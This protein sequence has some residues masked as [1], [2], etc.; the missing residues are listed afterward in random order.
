M[1]Q[2]IVAVPPPPSASAP[3]AVD[4]ALQVP[5]MPVLPNFPQY[6]EYP[7]FPPYEKAEK[8]AETTLPPEMAEPPIE[9]ISP[10][11]D[12][13]AESPVEDT[14]DII[15]GENQSESPVGYYGQVPVTM[16]FAGREI[17]GIIG[18]LNYLKNLADELPEK[19]KTS[20]VQSKIPSIMEKIVNNLKKLV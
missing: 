8:T 1:P 19:V 20:F 13:L 6:P 11:M 3:P 4:P 14:A 17:P 18:L 12:E 2:I 7:P 9:E 16:G 5:R 10:S 15:P